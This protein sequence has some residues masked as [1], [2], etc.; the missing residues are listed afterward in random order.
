MLTLDQTF[1]LKLFQKCF[2]K[3]Y[4]CFP[5]I[6][7]VNHNKSS[8]WNKNPVRYIG[9]FCLKT[10]Q[11]RK[12]IIVGIQKT[13]RGGRLSLIEPNYFSFLAKRSCVGIYFSPVG[14][15]V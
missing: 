7:P 8:W 1:K 14:L 13:G 3:R 5:R 4:R 9:F 11:S 10:F 15:W 2:T 12:Y 6:L